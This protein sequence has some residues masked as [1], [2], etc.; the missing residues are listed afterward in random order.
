M[1]P[2]ARALETPSQLRVGFSKKRKGTAP[3]PV[4]TAVSSAS[5]KT[6]AVSAMPTAGV[7]NGM[8]L[9][10]MRGSGA[11]GLRLYSHRRCSPQRRP[12]YESPGSCSVLSKT[13]HE[14]LRPWLIVSPPRR[15]T[16]LTSLSPWRANSSRVSTSSSRCKTKITR[17]YLVSSSIDSRRA[18]SAPTASASRRSRSAASA[19]S[20]LR[21]ASASAWRAESRLRQ[22]SMC[23]SIRFS[24]RS[25]AEPLCSP[26]AILLFPYARVLPNCTPISPVVP[27]VSRAVCKRSP[28][29]DL[30]FT[31]LRSFFLAPDNEHGT[32]GVADHRIG[33]A[34]DERPAEAARSISSIFSAWSSSNL[35]AASSARSRMSPRSSGDIILASGQERGSGMGSTETRCSSAP[36][37]SDSV[38]GTPS[39]RSASGEPS[40][41]SRILSPN[42]LT[43][44]SFSWFLR[45]TSRSSFDPGQHLERP[46]PDHILEASSLLGPYP[47]LVP[48][49]R[50]D[51]QP[52]GV[53][54]EDPG[55]F[56]DPQSGYVM[57]KL[58]FSAKTLVRH[59]DVVPDRAFRFCEC[60]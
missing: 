43:I 55:A 49:R 14:P 23:S 3:S 27:A 59:P 45:A 16:T 12:S 10:R 2:A 18:S 19:Q 54:G 42:A 17:F 46:D 41:A 15:G 8:R 33:D 35:R 20:R 34:T 52:R 53:L 24:I 56:L 5:R 57:G 37:L 58:M 11:R 40:V 13:S 21:L 25:M 29:R 60:I 1:S 50:E 4:A 38:A 7:R 36:S 48:A 26:I 32:V 6:H 39:A 51:G 9:H 30:R 47:A 28:W 22:S 44:S 31:L